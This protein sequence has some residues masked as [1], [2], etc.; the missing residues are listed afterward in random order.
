MKH[1]GHVQ[2]SLHAALVPMVLDFDF[3]DRMGTF[4][5]SIQIRRA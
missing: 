5:D 1:F 2:H 4:A 3:M